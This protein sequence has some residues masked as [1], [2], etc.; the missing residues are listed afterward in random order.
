MS[1]DC[2][3][4]SPDTYVGAKGCRERH[5]VEYNKH[6]DKNGWSRQACPFPQC[7]LKD[8]S[9][10]ET[11]C[12]ELL[13][14]DDCIAVPQRRCRW[15]ADGRCRP[16]CFP[17]EQATAVQPR[18]AATEVAASD[19]GGAI[20]RCPWCHTHVSESFCTA[21]AGCAWI[22]DFC[23][24]YPPCTMLGHDECSKD[25][26]CAEHGYARCSTKPCEAVNDAVACGSLPACVWEHRR[27]HA[28]SDTNAPSL[29]FRSVSFSTA[30]PLV[31]WAVIACTLFLWNRAAGRER[32]RA[33]EAEE[34]R[35]R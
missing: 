25:A 33:L 22:G 29:D 26:R 24:V 10:Q 21:Q 9:C 1:R 3:F 14:K 8:S 12:G 16:V 23:H 28:A 32:R 13:A 5:C 17:N 11:P 35:R 27:C 30:A 19:D 2:E 4:V 34:A 6:T 15:G 7:T 20:A 18:L 31:A